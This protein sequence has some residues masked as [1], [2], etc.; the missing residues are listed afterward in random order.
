M[1]HAACRTNLPVNSTLRICLW[2]AITLALLYIGSASSSPVATSLTGRQQDL[3][4][5]YKE[6]V[7][8]NTTNSVG[9]TTQAAKA[10]A[11][12]LVAA[13]LPAADVQVLVHPGN[14]RKGNVVARLRGDGTMKPILLLAHLDVVEANK[15]DWSAD[16]DPFKLIERDGYY[17][18]R[19]TLDD[20]SMAAIFVA[21][22]IRYQREHVKLKRDI[23]LALTADEEG[24][25]FNGA[26]W[27]LQNHRDLV[28]AQ[29]GLNEG[30][31][32]RERNDAAVFNTVQAAEKVYADFT[33]EVVNKGG[34]SS[35]PVKENAIY[36]L[37][38]GLD[39]LASFD[40]PV[41]LNE[42]TR[43]FFERTAAAEGGPLAAA[44]QKVVQSN[45]ADSEA[46]AQLSGVPLY[47]A[48]LR[49]T[50]VA[51]L[52]QAGHATNALPQK[53][54]ANVNC[55]ILP[56]TPIEEVQRTLVQVL[57]DEQIAVTLQRHG[58]PADQ[59][60]SSLDPAVM[61]P[62]EEL[63]RRMWKGVPTIPSMSTGATDSEQFRASG[64]PMYGVSGLFM[65][66]D[67]VRAHGRDERV[68]VRQFYVAQEFLY[69]LVKGY[70]VGAKAHPVGAR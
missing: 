33:L 30:G 23:I 60:L 51:T 4:D 5:I 66:I 27:L 21:N 42:V 41:G 61:R 14:A 69:E 43:S 67:D 47:N 44:M 56:Q 25:G 40:F 18:G 57:A 53:A 32:G 9:D 22:V 13:G 68:G 15:Q 6:L 20:K 59:T 11:A 36:R 37:A 50:C 26:S 2:S 16:L 46:V 49:T 45:G 65:D 62:I 17:Y 34:H 19:G 3:Y 7:E 12:R 54:T 52:M 64:I 8:I 28:E 35:L 1:K 55:R 24:G 48:T 63:T 38:R 58:T 10:M 70:A 31:G 29:F 39:R